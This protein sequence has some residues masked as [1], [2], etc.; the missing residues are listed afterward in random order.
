MRTR[1]QSRSLADSSR[2]SSSG[3]GAAPMEC[4]EIMPRALLQ[5]CCSL[6]PSGSCAGSETEV[7]N[8][9]P[10]LAHSF[11][12]SAESYLSKKRARRRPLDP[13]GSSIHDRFPFDGFDASH[14]VTDW[15]DWTS[16]EAGIVEDI[17]GRLLSLD[18][19]E[20]LRFRAVCKP[21]R[22]C[23]A[24]PRSRGGLD[25][26][27]RPRNWI[28]MSHCTSPS[29]RTLLNVA[30]GARLKVD[31]P[32]LS[33]HHHFGSA[34]GLLVL[35]DK[36]SNAIRLLNPLTGVLI[37]FPAISDVRALTVPSGAYFAVFRVNYNLELGSTK[38]NVP[39]PP[40]I[41]GAGIDDSTC[42]PTL[43]LC[44]R[45]QLSHVVCA[46]PGDR[47]W[48]SVH[49][50]EQR[51]DS[52]TA[53]G[54]I[55]FQSLLSFKGRCFFTTPRGDIM[56]VD[57][58]PMTSQRPPWKPR[59]VYVHKEMALGDGVTGMS[60]LAR[61]HDDRMLMVRYLFS[62]HSDLMATDGDGNPAKT[63]ISC[64]ARSLMEVLEIDINIRRMIPLGGIGNNA[65]FVGDTHSIMLSTDKF[66][67]LASNVV[68]MNYLW[69]RIRRFGSYCFKD[70]MITL[71]RDLRRDKKGRED[72]FFPCACH[73]E[74]DDYLICYVQ[75]PEQFH[76]I[77][78]IDY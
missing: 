20:Y 69:Q 74:L 15:R 30:T 23:T 49:H 45:K 55:L 58:G 73:L 54:R 46:K 59:M 2:K 7:S 78:F 8:P 17:A 42:P 5:R 50:G 13:S 27:F 70:G 64:G 47:H 38:V 16:L 14:G 19:V 36:T 48:V 62:C 40:V 32:E 28:A 52:V 18:V 37:E 71:P 11:I 76:N 68:Y 22:V 61:S 66:P 39:T 63:F 3:N 25:S 24:Y 10:D 1:S 65:V 4:E 41:K 72:G 26:R 51:V 77:L 6:D 67:K 56:T 33:T 21:W 29:R 60:Y 57:L 53:L 34:E 43:V 44:L 12:Y 9:N 75:Q 31:F 35:C